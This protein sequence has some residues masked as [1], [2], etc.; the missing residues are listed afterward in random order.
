MF[1]T[2]LKKGLFAAGLLAVCQFAS[3]EMVVIVHPSNSDALGSKEIQRLF[4]GKE[5]KLPSGTNAT[6]INLPNG[7]ATRTEFDSKVLERSSTQVAAYW[8]KLVFTGKGVPPKE[9]ANAA[10]MVAAV[11]ADP[12]AIGYV[13]S[14]AVTGAVK[15]I[16]IN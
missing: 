8:S 16:S 15:A 14:S 10:A 7:D 1:K 5:K 11:A 2:K 13:D 9:V 4:L 12:S 3:A 6:P